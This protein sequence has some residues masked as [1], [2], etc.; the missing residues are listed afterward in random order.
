MN[1]QHSDFEF[2]ELMK[3]ASS[4]DYPEEE[5]HESPED[6]PE[7]NFEVDVLS[8]VWRTNLFLEGE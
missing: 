3:K 4:K 5:T 6:N 7:S 1:Q 8:G 2:L